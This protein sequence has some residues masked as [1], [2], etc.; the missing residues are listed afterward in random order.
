MIDKENKMLYSEPNDKAIMVGA[1]KR[2]RPVSHL[3]TKM[4]LAERFHC[5]PSEIGSWK[6][7]D[8]FTISIAD[9]LQNGVINDMN[10]L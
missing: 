8:V 5:T 4:K 9:N 1:S 10:K 3:L 2:L 7:L 6:Y